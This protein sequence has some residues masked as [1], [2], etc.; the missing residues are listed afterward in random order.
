MVMADGR[1]TTPGTTSAIGAGGCVGGLRNYWGSMQPEPNPLYFKPAYSHPAFQ[2]R[3]LECFTRK[4]ESNWVC[5]KGFVA[6]ICP[7]VGTNTVTLH[8]YWRDRNPELFAELLEILPRDTK[9]T[10]FDIEWFLEGWAEHDNI[11]ATLKQSGAP[12]V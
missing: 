2:E 6:R 1:N 5:G 7:W 9:F 3:R 10:P 11:I 8:I 12:H 4:T